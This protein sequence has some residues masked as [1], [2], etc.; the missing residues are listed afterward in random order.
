ML[1]STNLNTHPQ[2]SYNSN[3]VTLAP[4]INVLYHKGAENK[5][6]VHI[7]LNSINLN[8]NPPKDYSSNAGTLALNINVPDLKDAKITKWMELQHT[9]YIKPPLWYQL[10]H[11]HLGCG[12]SKLTFNR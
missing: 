3:A 12:E 4:N 8:H 11:K 1:N 9:C 5:T 7:T 6:I 10:T 2:N